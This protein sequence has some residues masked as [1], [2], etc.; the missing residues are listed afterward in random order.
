M[1]DRVSGSFTYIN[2]SSEHT[3]EGKTQGREETKN[4]SGIINLDNIID[5]TDWTDLKV[6]REYNPAPAMS[7]PD[8]STKRPDITCRALK[9]M[10]GILIIP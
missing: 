5:E 9:L 8:W 7:N 6:L 2:P 10:L 4:C 1:L 3:I